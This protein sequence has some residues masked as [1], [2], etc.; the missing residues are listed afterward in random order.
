MNMDEINRVTIDV[1][2]TFK[3]L[4]DL[5]REIE[6]NLPLSEQDKLQEEMLN[7]A[8]VLIETHG[9]LLASLVVEGAHEI[10]HDVYAYGRDLNKD[11]RWM[12]EKKG[13]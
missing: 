7:L 9:V 1:P 13:E 10:I 3:V 8:K 12:E 6:V 2:E 11:W 5:S 4:R